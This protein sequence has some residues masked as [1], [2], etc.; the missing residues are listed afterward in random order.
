MATRESVPHCEFDRLFT[1]SVPHILEKIFFSLNYDSFMACGKVCVAWE[2]LHS[3]NRYQQRANELLKEKRQQEK[4]LRHYSFKNNV[5][6][7]QRILT[8]GVGADLNAEN[9][10]RQTPLHHA[11]HYG[12]SEIV[13][14]L[15]DGGALPDKVNVHDITPLILA[16]VE[17]HHNTVELLLDGGADPE[18]TN[19]TGGT[20]LMLAV[21]YGYEDVVKILLKK[22]VDPN[23]ADR[24]GETALNRAEKNGHRIVAKMIQDKMIENDTLHEDLFKPIYFPTLDDE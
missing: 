2:E 23:K 22:G 9:S 7:V 19:T 14:Q 5:E 17:G 24:Y 1:K 12:H 18:K 4:W 16:A 15:I 6:Q 3:S 21:S 8:S 11:A 13:K 10:S 20:P